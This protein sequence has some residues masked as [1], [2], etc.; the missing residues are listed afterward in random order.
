MH[1]ILFAVLLLRGL[2]GVLA[3]LPREGAL[4]GAREA[5]MGLKQVLLVL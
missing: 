4:Q 3:A 5:R 1:P 2:F